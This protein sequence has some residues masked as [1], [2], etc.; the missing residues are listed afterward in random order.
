M[1]LSGT[2]SILFSNF[3]QLFYFS[4]LLYNDIIYKQIQISLFN[5]VR[6]VFFDFLRFF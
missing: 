2:P 3:L 5:I 6:F 1:V 4:V